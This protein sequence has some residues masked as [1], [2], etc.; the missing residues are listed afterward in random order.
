MLF[1]PESFIAF[2][3]HEVIDEISS[4]FDIIFF[5]S[6][7]NNFSGPAMMKSIKK[8]AKRSTLLLSQ[9]KELSKGLSSLNHL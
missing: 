6:H 1:L 9:W 3:G 5:F 8:K 4:N 2:L 7:I